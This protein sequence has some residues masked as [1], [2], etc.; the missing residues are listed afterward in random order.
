MNFGRSLRNIFSNPG[1][2]TSRWA[3]WLFWAGLLVLLVQFGIALV[4]YAHAASAALQ[5][6]Y[7]LDYQEGPALDQV[8]RFIHGEALYRTDLTTPPFVISYDPPL[9]PL[10]QAPLALFFGPAYWYGRALS[11]LGSLLAALFVGLTLH[12]ITRDWIG[13][14][15]G[16]LTLLVYPYLLYGSLLTRPDTLAL[17]F[18]LA[19]IFVIVRKPERKSNLALAAL[20]FTL[21]VAARQS[22]YLAAPLAAL[23]WLAH[24]RLLRQAAWLAGLTIAFWLVA[25]LAANLLTHGGLY[26][27]LV[28]ANVAPFSWKAVTAAFSRFLPDTYFLFLGAIMYLIVEPISDRSPVWPLVL[29]YL[30]GALVSTV[31]ASGRT[32]STNASFYELAAAC[33]LAAGAIISWVRGTVW[34]KVFLVLV[35]AAQIGDLASWAQTSFI[36]LVTAKVADQ[37][38]LVQVDQM[39]RSADGL[40]LAD[41]YAG[42]LPLAGKPVLFQPVEF[43]LLHEM[44]GWDDQPIIDQIN[45]KAYRYIMVYIPTDNGQYLTERWSPDIREALYASYHSVD[46]LGSVYI[47]APKP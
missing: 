12:A 28:E 46:T 11:L 6:P 18:S 45:Q 20:L 32:S 27:T 44:V 2:A 22:Y 10:A 5:F 39:V 24:K 30:F 41:E 37:R 35:L 47:Y 31:L 43:K 42:M 17:A 36:P 23:A 4:Q 21:A 29:S 26:F 38:E 34:V 13:A 16:G 19:G 9:Y 25:A 8:V 14:S 33:A 7:P 15:I 1:E 40:V 3:T